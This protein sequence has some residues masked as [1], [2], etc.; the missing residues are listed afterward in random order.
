LR[1]TVIGG[2]RFFPG[3]VALY[4]SFLFGI[5]PTILLA[6][7]GKTT[8][9]FSRDAHGLQKQFEPLLK[10]YA[11]GDAATINKEYGVFILPNANHWFEDNFPASSAQQLGWDYDSE[12]EQFK[13][14]LPGMMKILQSGSKFNARC[15]PPDPT[16]KTKLQPNADAVQPTNEI[17]LEQFEVKFVA[18]NGRSFSMLCNF[19]YVDGAYR[20]LGKGAYPFW[21]MPDA[22]RK[23]PSG[24]KK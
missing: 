15:S 22:T 11:K 1:D 6:N 13:H 20:F 18:D 23:A 19:V 12:A 16:R 17:P 3:F 9:S 10:A 14:T 5:A 24:E 21:S 2:Q 4:L 8:K 7:D